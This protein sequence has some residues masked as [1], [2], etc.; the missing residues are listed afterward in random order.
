MTVID[1]G[2]VVTLPF[3]G[4]LTEQQESLLTERKAASLD[5]HHTGLGPRLRI[6]QLDKS[7]KTPRKT[8]SVERDENF[9]YFSSK[10]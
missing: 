5:L 7:R 3:F 8:H 1:F 4:E 6:W 9:V 2:F 10:H